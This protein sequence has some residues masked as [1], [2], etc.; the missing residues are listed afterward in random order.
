MK[1]QFLALL[2]TRVL[3]S[4]VQAVSIV[5]LARW[6]GIGTFGSIAV[7]V[8]IS[9]VL[10][11]VSDWGLSSYIPR[12]RA[13]GSQGEV[14]TGLRMNFGGNAVAGT[15]LA[16]VVLVIGFSNH[17]SPWLCILPL[18]L[19]LDQFTETGL[20]VA[21]A[22]KL[23]APV[24]VSVLLRRVSALGIFVGFHWLGM[25]ASAAY[26][27]SML[28]SA[29]AG[30][31]HVLLVLRQRL[32]GVTERVGVRALY[33][34]L[35]PYMVANL[36]TASRQLDSSI[37]AATTSVV[38]AGLYS[39]A[40]RLTRPLMLIGGA[41]VAVIL[42]HAARENLST[43]QRLARQLSGMAALSLIPCAV[44]AYLS[45]HIVVLLF[46]PGYVAAGPAFALAVLAIP[47]LSLAPPLGGMLQGQGHPNFVAYNGMIFAAITLLMIWGGAA[48][49]GA[50]GAA[51]GILVSYAL[52]VTALLFRL[53][54]ATEAPEQTV[55]EPA[56]ASVE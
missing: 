35:T 41:A 33:K 50:T 32:R 37:V 54:R 24:V 29:L 36:S 51:L 11:T 48:W 42:P 14:A 21:V 55:L 8:G 56:T 27:L 10:F 19:A 25:G 23:K 7:V 47:F 46:G 16:V 43:V 22:D 6:V 17:S 52:K 38:S 39:A 34:L 1:I 9:G 44:V 12:A 26:S 40:F 13:K 3:A 28:L 18:A 45:P 53:L 15:L 4:G 20:T 5:L 2:I 31:V 49:L 30:L